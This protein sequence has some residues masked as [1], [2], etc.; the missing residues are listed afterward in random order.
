MVV[1]REPPAASPW[2][3]ACFDLDGTLVVGTTTSLHLA[4]R[5]GHVDL[6]R[7]LER[8]YSAGEI[9]NHQIA[10]DTARFFAGVH[11]EAAE[12]ALESIPLIAG[13][14][15]T[16]DRL[17]AVGVTPL[18]CTLTWAFASR[19]L[20]SRFGFEAA[21]GTPMDESSDGRLLGEVTRHFDEYDKRAFVEEY[22]HKHNIPLNA[23]FAVGDSRSDIPLFGAVGFSVA[24]NVTADARRAA[25]VTLDTDNLTDLFSVLP[26][27]SH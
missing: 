23:C 2:K 13:I 12:K 21:S 18:L 22:C 15:E 8:R 10:D 20:G 17:R 6:L 9:S 27:F 5:F 4:D 26:G 11:P 7:D 16:L 14:P 25:S 1:D 3:L 24:L 19:Y